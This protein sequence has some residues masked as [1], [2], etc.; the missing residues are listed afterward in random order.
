MLVSDLPTRYTVHRIGMSSLFPFMTGG[1]RHAMVHQVLQL[2][3]CSVRIDPRAA[4]ARGRHVEN[5]W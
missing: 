3:L 1:M 4:L 2:I 5:Q